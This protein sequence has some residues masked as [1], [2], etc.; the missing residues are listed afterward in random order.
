MVVYCFGLCEICALTLLFNGYRR[1]HVTDMSACLTLVPVAGFN[2]KRSQCFVS[3]S[4]MF[5]C[6]CI[7]A[8]L[9]LSTSVDRVQAYGRAEFRP[10]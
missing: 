9:R 6:I 10:G 5:T 2:S 1:E 4:M 8:M 7:I 3:L